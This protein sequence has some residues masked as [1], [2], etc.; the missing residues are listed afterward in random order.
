M[1]PSRTRNLFKKVLRCILAEENGDSVHISEFVSAEEL[2][3]VCYD[4]RL[5]ELAEELDE[6]INNY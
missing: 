1:N 2:K 6:I 3:D 5:D 4:L